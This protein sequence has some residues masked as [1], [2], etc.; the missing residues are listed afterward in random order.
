MKGELLI[1]GK[2]AWDTWG[3]SIGEGFLESLLNPPPLKPFVENNSRLQPG[4]QVLY[5]SPMWDERDLNLSIRIEGATQKE[6]LQRYA[7]FTRELQ[8]G[9]LVF[10]VPV[11]ESTYK[12]TYIGASRLALNIGRT[13]SEIAFKFNEPNPSDRE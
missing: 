1:N 11:L 9:L 13:F 12:L 6:Y 8:K 4:K 7:A 2:D 10:Y 5:S 3:V